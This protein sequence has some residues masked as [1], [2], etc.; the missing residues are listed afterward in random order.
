MNYP[1]NAVRLAL[2]AAL[3]LGAVQAQ[4][5]GVTAGTQVDNSFTLEY[6]VGGVSQPTATSNTTSFLVDRKIDLTVAED[7]G[8]ATT[9][10]PGATAQ[11]L[12]YTVTNLSNSPLDIRLVASHQVGGAGP[13]GGTDNFDATGLLV[14][15]ESGANA[16]YQPLEDI[17]T[18]ID[19][20]AADDD[21][22][23]YVVG[24]IPSGRANGDVS[25]VLLTAIAA[26][27]TDGTGAYVAT[28]GTLAADAAETNTGST[29]NT[30][31]IDTVFADGAGAAPDVAENGQFAALDQYTVVTA[32]IAVS[33]S[34]R[35]VSDP[36]NGTTNPKAIP[37]AV[38]EYCLDV[39]NTGASAAGTLVLTDAIPTNTTYVAS[40]I[41]TAVT[42]TGAACDDGPTTGVSEDDND[43][44]A[45]ETDPDG[46]D[47]NATTAGAVTVRTPAI[48]AGDRFKATFRVTVD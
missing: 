18:F 30:A 48:A 26:Q 2:A 3:T 19:E 31:F 10:V 24:D 21:I 34:S 22:T 47:H 29:D 37:G 36:F 35:V 1:K 9:V 12:T 41:Y 38:I 23:V 8:A 33:K 17:A 11:V 42:G 44:G 14:F 46:A 28:V 32:T 43:A 20:L 5:A 40:S 39:N 15:V 7:G 4:A 45:D 13:F 6:Q 16:G 27:S 25:A